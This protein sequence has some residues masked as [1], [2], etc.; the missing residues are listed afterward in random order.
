VVGGRGALGRSGLYADGV[1]YNPAGNRW[2]S[3]P[4]MDTSRIGHTAVWTG[5]RLLVWGGQTFRAGSWVAPP[6]GVAYDPAR[7]RWSPLPKSPLR[8]RTGHLA[9]WTG[10]QMLI[11]GG[12]SI[13]ADPST[14]NSTTF[15]DG[16]VYTANAL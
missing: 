11:W 8:G 6:H 16:A 15:V 3:L 7:N 2:R 13:V 5:Q 9:V 4:A 1:A 14:A 12:R 10:T